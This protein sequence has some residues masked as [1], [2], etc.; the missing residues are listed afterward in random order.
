MTAAGQSQ[1]RPSD[2]S[3]TEADA[4]RGTD[5]RAPTQL[6]PPAWRAILWRVKDE[7][8]RD[9]VLIVA[10]GVTFYVIL[11][12]VPLLTAFVALYGLFADRGSVTRLLD[13]V[14]GAV[15]PEMMTLISDQLDRLLSVE[16]GTLTLTSIIALLIAF[17]S[18]NGG[19]KGLI[20]AMNVAYDEQ[21]ARSFV[22]RNLVAM[23]MTLGGMALVAVLIALSAV[24]PAVVALFPGSGLRDAVLMWGR[25]PVMAALLILTLAVL[26]R[27]G[28]DRRSAKW[29]WITPGAM[30]AA[31][32]MIAVSAGFSFYTANFAAYG[33]TYGSLGAVIVAMMWFWLNSIVLIVGAEINAEIE[34]QTAQDSTVGPD[35]PMGEREAVMADKVA[36]PLSD[37]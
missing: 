8:A 19:V 12:L 3:G 9:R 26:Y 15:P 13:G 32:G 36:P 23:S 1:D 10:G 24:V 29:R 22:K 5:A 6:P 21:E 34:H 11:S 14:E 35:R 2:A 31:V 20:E 28:P 16:P 4:A 27:F 17:W 7:I 25:W 18:A 37:S 30:V 33:D